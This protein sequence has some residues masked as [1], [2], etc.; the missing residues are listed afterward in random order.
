MIHNFSHE[1]IV[2]IHSGLKNGT[3]KNHD[4]RMRLIKE[5]ED[6]FIEI[7]TH[8]DYRIVKKKTTKEAK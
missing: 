1:E 7:A 5:F 2:E 3:W 8:P 4:T 6:Y